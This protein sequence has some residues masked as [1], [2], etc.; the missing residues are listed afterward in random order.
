MA[1]SAVTSGNVPA[2]AP[3]PQAQAPQRI[4]KPTEKPAPPAP[5]AAAPA[6]APAPVVNTSGQVTGTTINTSA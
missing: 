6:P 2:A 1:V 3:A 4:D 5:Q